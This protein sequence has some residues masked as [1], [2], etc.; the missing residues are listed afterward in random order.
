MGT[1]TPEGIP[2]LLV[3]LTFPCLWPAACPQP[4]PCLTCRNSMQCTS[5]IEGE[6][7]GGHWFAPSNTCHVGG[8]E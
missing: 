8:S 4:C 5:T 2:V 7:G 1:A 6:G 3:G